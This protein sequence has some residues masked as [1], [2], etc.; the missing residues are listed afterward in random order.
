M[1]FLMAALWV[2]PLIWHDLQTPCPCYATYFHFCIARRRA[3]KMGILEME[4]LWYL[5]NVLLN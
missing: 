3:L 4:F 5:H 2:F 1:S